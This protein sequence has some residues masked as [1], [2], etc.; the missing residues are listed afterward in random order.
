MKVFAYSIT[1][2][3]AEPNGTRVLTDMGVCLANSQEQANGAAEVAAAARFPGLNRRVSV[4]EIPHQMMRVV[5][6]LER[7]Q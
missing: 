2:M 6:G 5:L 7:N 4:I 1:A 3:V